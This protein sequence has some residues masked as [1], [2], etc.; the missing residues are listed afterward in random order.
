MATGL[1]TV[2]CPVAKLDAGSVIN[3]SISAGSAT[4]DAEARK[5]AR[6]AG[7]T[8]RYLFEPVAIGTSVSVGSTTRAFLLYLGSKLLFGI[9]VA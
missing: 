8:D 4:D 7:I 5:R 2:A 9:G 3:S 6:Y 1:Y